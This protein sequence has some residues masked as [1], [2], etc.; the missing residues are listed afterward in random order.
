[1]DKVKLGKLN[2]ISIYIAW[3]FLALLITSL[4]LLIISQGLGLL[5]FTIS[6]GGLLACAIIHGILG[7]LVRCPNFNKCLTVQGFGKNFHYG[8]R[9]LVGWSYVA[10]RWFSGS[11]QCIHCGVEVNTN[12]LK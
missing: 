7:Y 6:L 3:V 10:V 12:K 5:L 9:F 1:M 11:V 4:I 8:N 2:V